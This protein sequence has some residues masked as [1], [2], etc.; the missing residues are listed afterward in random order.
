MGQT[1]ATPTYS[2][3][4]GTYTT[5]QTV[6][7]ATATSGA[8]IRYT[9]NGSNPSET[10]GT[11]YSG[12]VAI[13]S[14]TTLKAIAYAS[15]MADSSVNIGVFTITPVATPTYSPVAGTYTTTQTVTIATATSGASIRYT[16]DGTNPTETAGTLYSGPVAI[17]STTTLKA[18]A[19]A[20]GMADS[21]V[22]IGVFTIT[23]VATPTYSPVAGTYTTIQ[24]VSIAT[25]TSGASIRYTTNGSNPSETAGTLYSGPITIASTTTLKAIA[26]A[27]G[28][29]D[30]SVNIGVFTIT[31]VATPTYSPVAGTYTTI[32]TV[33]IATA[34][35][36]A[37]IRYTTDGSN[38]SETAGTLYSGPITIASTTTLKAIAYASGMPDSSVNIGVF[39][40]TPVATPTYSPVAGTYTTIQTVSIATATS[41]AS[42]RYTTDGSNPSETAGTLYSGPITIA[43]TTTLKAIAYAS[44]MA[45]SSVNIGVFTIQTTTV[46]TPA[47][48]PAPGSYTTT[49]S[50]TISTSTSGSTIRFTTDGSTPSE[51][52]GTVYSGAITVSGT[53]T[54]NA[55]AYESGYTDSAVAT[56]IYTIQPP[57]ITSL[58]PTSGAAGVQVTISGS[59]FGATQGSG[60]VWLGTTPGAVV[61]W[62]NTQV[63]AT[64]SPGATSGLAQVQEYGVWSNSV[65]FNV[66]TATITNVTPASGL[67]GTQ[68]TIT[69]SG[70]GSAQGSG[71]VWLGTA[72]AV[73]QSWSDTQVVAAVGAGAVSGNAQVLQGGVM[74]NA[75][76]FNVNLPHTTSVSPTSGGAGNV[77]HNYRHRLRIVAGQRHGLAGEPTATA[78]SWSDT[79]VVAVVASGALTGIARVQQNSVWSN[80]LGFTVPSGSN[81]TL[82]PDIINLAVGDTQAIQALGSNGQPVTGLTWASS[83]PTVV[84]LSTDDPPILSALGPGHVTITGGTASADV[85]VNAAPLPSGTV[86]WSNPGDGSGAGSVIPAVPSPIGLADVFALQNDGTVQALTTQGIT[87]W[88]LAVP[89]GAP[90]YGSGAWTYASVMPD[91]QGGL[92]VTDLLA[93][94]GNGSIMKVDGITGQPYPAYTL[95]RLTDNFVAAAVHTDGTIFVLQTDSVIGIN[96]TTGTQKFSVP[97]PIPQ[98]LVT[99][100][101][102][103]RSGA[104]I[105]YGYGEQPAQLIVAG[106]GNAYVFYAYNEYVEE[107][108]IRAT[109]LRL[110]Q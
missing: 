22:N 95:A 83:D 43:S 51:T 42:I 20:S 16:T 27:S 3:V 45:D 109:H 105:G 98:P 96:P 48:S 82:G 57:S 97:L 72:N 93:N 65:S 107:C 106:D 58:S 36:G 33:S 92:V 4:A 46:A 34:T 35:S 66:N 108:G 21:A 64:V 81:L 24:T 110:L 94:G 52:A 26:Y 31:P 75:V 99:L 41:G 63:A 32:Q 59:G 25:A 47:F 91:F 104:D 88:S 49:Q 79:Q 61:S 77:R 89:S 14:T 2:P 29:P 100:I 40:I 37:S 18:I 85:T 10:A 28:M 1:V 5:I 19:Y 11:L 50:V 54:I 15:G 103:V 86:L 101:R 62:S 60:K 56:A 6:T 71:Q 70:F 13:G 30:S 17:G 38:P 69:G 55:I 39:T 67:P 74:S 8:S 23:P 12:P 102:I 44:G 84:S 90:L 76:S 9:T 80:A 87:A 78:V 53:T 73:V 7:I 68:V